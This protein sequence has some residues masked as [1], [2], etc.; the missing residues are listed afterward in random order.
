MARTLDARPSK[1][2]CIDYEIFNV[3]AQRGADDA[4]ADRVIGPF[5]SGVS[6]PPEVQERPIGKRDPVSWAFL[7]RNADQEQ[8]RLRILKK[9]LRF[10][11]DG[12]PAP[13]SALGQATSPRLEG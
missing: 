3:S 11:T 9:T 7:R 13:R 10:P 12:N 2:C 4:S 1:A 5:A 8:R 6:L